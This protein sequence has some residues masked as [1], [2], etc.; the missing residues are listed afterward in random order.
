MCQLP[1]L[2]DII[3]LLE[4]KYALSI[5]I[6]KKEILKQRIESVRYTDPKLILQVKWQAD[7]LQ[8]NIDTLAIIKKKVTDLLKQI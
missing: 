1:L 3:E 4:L 8:E 6:K 2:L 7:S 5:S